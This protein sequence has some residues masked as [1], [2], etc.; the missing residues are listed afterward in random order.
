LKCT[1]IKSSPN[2]Y[3]QLVEPEGKMKGVDRFVIAFGTMSPYLLIALTVFVAVAN[4]EG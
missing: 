2:G 1:V 3:H 4:A